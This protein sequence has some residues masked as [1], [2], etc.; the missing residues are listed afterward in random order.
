MQD[1]QDRK[2]ILALAPVVAA[3]CSQHGCTQAQA[4]RCVQ[5]AAAY[6]GFGRYGY[7]N[8]FWML[9]G[10]GDAGFYT[11]TRVWKNSR[12]AKD[13]G[14]VP[15][16]LKLAKFSSPAAGVRAWIKANGGK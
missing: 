6:S 1:E 16:T 13:G 5:E 10:L 4:K 2:F 15:E 14:W 7:A 3:V 11:V 12:T 9:P 8:N